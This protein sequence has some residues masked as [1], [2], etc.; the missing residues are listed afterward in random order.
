MN[1]LQTTIALL[2]E[3]KRKALVAFLT[4]GYPDIRAT[5]ESVYLLEKNGVDII[6][7]GVPFSDPIADGPTIQ[8][9]SDAALRNGVTLTAVLLLVSAIRKK[10]NIPIVLMGYLNP[11]YHH[12]IETIFKRMKNAGV[13]GL[14]IPDVIPEE[15]ADLRRVAQQNGL[16]LICMA[17]PN[18]PVDRLAY[19]DRNSDGFVYVVSLMG[20]TGGRKQLPAHVKQF[21]SLTK[22]HITRHPRFLGFGI[23]TPQQVK[24]LKSYVDGVIVGSALINILSRF[25]KKEERTTQ[26]ARFV[27][28]LRAAL[29]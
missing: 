27:A 26:L 6:E 22:K 16:S 11:L 28:S 23:S 5:E 29:D 20:V 4:A 19:I 2:K 8:A 25:E 17:A 7:L 14:I 9:A 10:S 13:D 24:E 1:R 18:S 3:Q 21:L 15:S 12:G